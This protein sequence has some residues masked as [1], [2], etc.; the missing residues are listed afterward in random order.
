M[1]LIKVSYYATVRM[2]SSLLYNRNG[3]KSEEKCKPC[4]Q[5]LSA[6]ALIN[7]YM[8]KKEKTIIIP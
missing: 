6:S 2:Y 5:G 3:E 4:L 7:E 8:W 1:A